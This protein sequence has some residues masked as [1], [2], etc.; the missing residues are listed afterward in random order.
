MTEELELEIRS[1]I[2]SFLGNTVDP[3]N[4]IQKIITDSYKLVALTV[5]I[6]NRI[7]LEIP[8]KYLVISNWKAYDEFVCDVIEYNE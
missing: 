8:D 2:E 1:V 5:E 3:L 7:N 4:D 6:E